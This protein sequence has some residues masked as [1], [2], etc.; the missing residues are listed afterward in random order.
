MRKR[1]HTTSD[2]R[3][4]EGQWIPCASTLSK[5]SGTQHML[6]TVHLLFC[7]RWSQLSKCGSHCTRPFLCAASS[8]LPWSA[9]ISLTFCYQLFQIYREMLKGFSV[10]PYIP[11]IT[12]F[13][14]QHFIVYSLL[15]IYPFLYHPSYFFFGCIQIK[16]QISEYFP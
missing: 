4:S 7:T 11:T 2:P 13:Y 16:L 9:L 6:A 15:P 8:L 10:N 14:H 5:A 3:E 12:R 1:S